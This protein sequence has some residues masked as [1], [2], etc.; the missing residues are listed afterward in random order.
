MLMVPYAVVG[1]TR[2]QAESA[3]PQAPRIVQRPSRWSWVRR[4]F[5]PSLTGA[6]D[7]DKVV[8]SLELV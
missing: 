7:R 6:P 8:T 4:A 2:S 1:A 3:L 5:A